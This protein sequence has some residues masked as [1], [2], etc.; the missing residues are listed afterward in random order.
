MAKRWGISARVLKNAAK[1]A[2]PNREACVSER[3]TLRI[4]QTQI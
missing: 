2:I 3:H 4:L 1:Y